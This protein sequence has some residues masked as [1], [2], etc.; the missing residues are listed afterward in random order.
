[1]LSPEEKFYLLAVFEKQ[2]EE[3]VEYVLT[4]TA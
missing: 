4:Y 1:M 2:W 3:F